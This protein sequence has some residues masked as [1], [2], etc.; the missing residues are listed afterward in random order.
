MEN[1][2]EVTG[3]F[4]SEAG[5]AVG[6]TI[7]ENSPPPGSKG[8]VEVFVR[9]GDQRNES[10]RELSFDIPSDVPQLE[11]LARGFAVDGHSAT[12]TVRPRFDEDDGSLVATLA[13]ALLER[14]Q[15]LIGWLELECEYEVL[16]R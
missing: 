11:A 16:F 10:V 6:F 3:H 4:S 7:N 1:F 5:P 15:E 9:L 2:K 13:E 14:Q 8:R 12:C